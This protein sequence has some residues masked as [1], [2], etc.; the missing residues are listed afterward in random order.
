MALL[1]GIQEDRQRHQ[2]ERALIV[3]RLQDPDLAASL[4]GDNDD[5]QLDDDPQ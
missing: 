5:V 2:G 4:Y 3:E 1:I